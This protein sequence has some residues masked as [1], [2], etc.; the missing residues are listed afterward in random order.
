MFAWIQNLLGVDFVESAEEARGKLR[1]RMNRETEC[2]LSRDLKL[3]QGRANGSSRF[4]L[5]AARNS[6][7]QSTDGNGQA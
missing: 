7:W 4:Q 3:G 1:L 6:R 5:A 2:I